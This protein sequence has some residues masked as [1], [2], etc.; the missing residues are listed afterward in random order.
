MFVVRRGEIKDLPRALELVHELAV[1]EKAPDAVIVDLEEMVDCFER[2]KL[3]DFL[4]LEKQEYIIGIAIYHY[5]YSTWKGKCL[6]LEDLIVTE[7]ERNKGYGKQLFEAIHQITLKENLPGTYW[8]V[9]DWN[10]S[11]IAFYK[12]FGAQFDDTWIN[13]KLTNTPF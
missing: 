5:K 2:Q 9:L 3:F 4:V 6:Y 11:A 10:A 13:C 1:F 8:Q 12:K 7:K